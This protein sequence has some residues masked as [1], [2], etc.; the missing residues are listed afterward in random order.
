M[1]PPVKT[2]L[3]RNGSLDQ[4][5][6]KTCAHLLDIPDTNPRFGLKMIHQEEQ[7]ESVAPTTRLTV[8]VRR[9]KRALRK[10]CRKWIGKGFRIKQCLKDG[11]PLVDPR[12]V[13]F[14]VNGGNPAL[15]PEMLRDE[16]LGGYFQS[17]APRCSL[18]SGEFCR[19]PRDKSGK[20]RKQVATRVINGSKVYVRI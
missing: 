8:F 14:S 13:A 18:N 11:L 9:S 3:S 19:K 17:I 4:F 20:I 10:F 5:V 12:G 7:G 16:F 6:G 2:V 15:V 1:V